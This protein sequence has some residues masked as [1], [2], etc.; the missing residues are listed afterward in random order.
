MLSLT[1][2]LHTCNDGLR[3]GRCLETA[4]A[5]NEIVIVDHGSTDDTLHVAHEFG[6][7]IVRAHWETVEGNEIGPVGLGAR[8]VLC[9]DPRE[10]L[11]EAL[12]ASLL[13]WK[14]NEADS[15]H[16]GAR[17][18]LLRE[19]NAHGWVENPVPQTRLVPAK[20]DRWKGRFPEN[21]PS[22]ATLEGKLLRFAFP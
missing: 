20:W 9:L 1:A 10:A 5:C 17:A 7:K 8:W 16:P 4:Y 12:A 11:S 6:A 13:E 18:I 22:S 3:L 19:E 15:Q 2:L 21:H 14:W